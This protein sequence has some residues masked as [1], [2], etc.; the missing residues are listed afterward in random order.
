MTKSDQYRRTNQVLRTYFDGSNPKIIVQGG[1][2]SA[3][4]VDQQRDWLY[5]SDIHSK[6][7]HSCD[8]DGQDLRML[9]QDVLVN[10]LTIYDDK[11]YYAQG[12]TQ[13]FYCEKIFCKSSRIVLRGQT[14]I[15]D[16]HAVNGEDISNRQQNPCAT[17]NGDCSHICFTDN[18]GMKKCGCPSGLD[19][20]M[21]KM[22]CEPTPTCAPPDLVCSTGQGQVTCIPYEWRCDGSQECEDGSDEENCPQTCGAS[23]FKCDNGKCIDKSKVCDRIAD[24]TDDSDET[25]TCCTAGQ[26]MCKSSLVCI[27]LKKF[28]DGEPDCADNS[29]ELQQSPV[30]QQGNPYAV[31]IIVVLC[32]VSVFILFIIIF[33]VWK[34]HK[35]STS[36]RY[37]DQGMIAR[38]VTSLDSL[39][40]TMLD[41]VPQSVTA[42]TV[43]SASSGTSGGVYDRNHVTGASS[44]SSSMTH[45]QAGFNPPP[46][47]VTE[48]SAFIGHGSMMDV[49]D[50]STLVSSAYPLY[51]PHGKRLNVKVPPTTP[52]S[53]C[54]DSEPSMVNYSTQRPIVKRKRNKKYHLLKQYGTAEPLPPPPTPSRSQICSADEASECPPSPSTVR[55]YRST[56]NN[57][58]PPPPSPEPTSDNS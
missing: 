11:L 26:F 39:G 23:E 20:S 48:R 8:S 25:S 7:I 42:T 43:I 21:N 9:V 35:R 24:C 54:D 31:G 37:T 28:R 53:T 29:D 30:A 32:I 52:I 34:C 12:S 6:T 22:S 10:T 3:I 45:L 40:T 58:Y 1:M 51:H 5:Y 14:N 18:Y 16:V 56:I 13:L 19:L 17:N 15:T 50:S 27:P 41:G 49:D 47:P 33:V 57:P 46:S 2:I 4:A 36:L 55:S 44:S 38:Q